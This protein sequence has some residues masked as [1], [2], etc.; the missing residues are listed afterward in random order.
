MET[1]HFSIQELCKVTALP[2]QTIIE[3][4]DQGIIDPEGSDPETWLFN[5]QMV[6]I[7]KKACRLHDDLEIDWSRI[8]LAISLLEELEQ[9]RQENLQLKAQLNRFIVG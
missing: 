9:M 8:A 4:V 6:S 1:Q 2:S 5:M 3:I 7:T